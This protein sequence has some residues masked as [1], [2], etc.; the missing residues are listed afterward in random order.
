MGIADR[1]F[2]AIKEVVTLSQQVQGLS[3][4]VKALNQE[5]RSLDRRVVRL[6]TMAEIVERIR[7]LPRLEGDGVKSSNMHSTGGANHA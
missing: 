3:E 6:E 4:E 1:F 2:E 7:Q 5:T